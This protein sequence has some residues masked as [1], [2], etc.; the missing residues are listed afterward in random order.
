MIRFTR[1][2]SLKMWLVASLFALCLFTIVLPARAEPIGADAYGRSYGEWSASWWQWLRSIPADVLAPDGV[3]PGH[4]LIAEGE[5][6]CSLNQPP[7]PVWFLAGTGGEDATRSCVVP[8]QKALFFPLV[9][10]MFANEEGEN[11]TVE[12]KRMAM[13]DFLRLACRLDSKLDGTPTVFSLP[14]VRIQ[15]PPFLI[16]TADPDIFGDDAL[17]D[18]EAVADGFWVTVPPLPRGEHVLEFTGSLCEPDT[19]EPFFTVNVTYNLSVQ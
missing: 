1:R 14:T 11:F 7:G 17:V 2:S 9:N 8:R 3:S 15:S 4:P 19:G 6:D 12:E 5:V 10:I 18:P 16:E 13:D